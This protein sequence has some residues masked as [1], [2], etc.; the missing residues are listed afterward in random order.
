LVSQVTITAPEGQTGGNS[1]YYDTEKFN[2]A[3]AKLPLIDKGHGVKVHD[4]K[5]IQDL[6]RACEVWPEGVE[7]RVPTEG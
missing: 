3:L 5:Q 7:P 4:S 1:P 6:L 2:A